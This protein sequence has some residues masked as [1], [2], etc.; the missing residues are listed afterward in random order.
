MARV[1]GMVGLV[2][3][4]WGFGGICCRFEERGG[5]FGPIWLGYFSQSGYLELRKRDTALI[6]SNVIGNDFIY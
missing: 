1:K 5:E 3:K 6:N 4:R 2:G